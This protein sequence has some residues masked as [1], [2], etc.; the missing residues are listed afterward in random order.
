MTDVLA[1]LPEFSWRGVEYPLLRASH[2]FE[3]AQ[4]ETKLIY[5]NGQFIEQLGANV[6]WCK[7]TL[8]MRED[9]AVGSFANLFTVGLLKL[10]EDMQNPDPGDLVDPVYGDL[11]M[12]PRS[13]SDNLDPDKRDGSDVELE[14]RVY[15]ELGEETQIAG[16]SIEGLQGDTERLDDE[17]EAVTRAAQVPSPQPATDPL[18]AI[19]GVGAQ[20]QRNR[21]R[22]QASLANTSSKLRKIENQIDELEDP[23]NGD[24]IRE[25]RRL[26]V[27]AA[28]LSEK[29]E[30][31]RIVRRVTTNSA[32][33]L[34]EVAVM[35]GATVEELITLN[36]SLV[37]SP[38]VPR[39]TSVTYYG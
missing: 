9:I 17:V 10:F 38:T 6:L 37:K 31:N 26:Q 28:R 29:A 15:N 2:G 14:F 39:G 12:V 24:I 7:Y 1:A 13:F 4:A 27:D 35:V 22:V 25:A 11:L 16:A 3:H 5:R 36:P 21:S 18:S 20:L 19:A 30:P 23:L 8:S 32:K 34:T 33:S